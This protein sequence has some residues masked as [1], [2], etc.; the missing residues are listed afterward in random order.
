MNGVCWNY[1]Q[2]SNDV[3]GFILEDFCEDQNDPLWFD[4]RIKFVQAKHKVSNMSWLDKL[5]TKPN[6]KAKFGIPLWRMVSMPIM[7][8]TLLVDIRKMEASFQLRYKEGD[9]V[10][11]ASQTNNL[12]EDMDVTPKIEHG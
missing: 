5:K 11:Y 7:H 10:F 6:T 8:S 1:E 9:Q 2:M 4:K 3:D 12:G